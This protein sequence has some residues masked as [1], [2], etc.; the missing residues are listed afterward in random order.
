M[1]AGSTIT[2][3]FIRA[4]PKTDL[5]VH[6]DGSLRLSTLIE[7]ARR[8][9]VP[10]PSYDESGL[11]T[12]VFKEAYADLG[13]YLRGFAYTCAVLQSADN[14]ERVAYELAAD[15]IAEG[16]RYV[17]VRFAPQLHV[18]DA[19][20]LEQV[21][22]AVAAGMQRAK[23]EHNVRSEVRAQDDVPFEFGLILCAMRSFNEHMGPY[24]ARLLSVMDHTPRKRVFA[25]ASVELARAA[26]ILARESAL[27]VVGFDLAG[28]ESGFPAIDHREAYQ[29]AQ[30]NFLSKTVHAGE[31]YGPESIFQAIT[32]CHTNR[33]GHGTFLFD[34][35]KVQDDDV[36]DAAAYTR[37]LAEYIAARRITVEVCPTSN[38]QTTPQIRSVAEHPV[39]R[40]IEYGMSVTI[41]TDNRLVSNTTVS[42]ELELVAE[43]LPITRRQFRN[44]VVAGFKGSFFP[45]PYR[46]KRAFVRAAIDR[47]ERLERELLG[48]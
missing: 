9:G 42:R 37:S 4:I 1:I 8:E 17:E 7:L 47:Y 24:F 44:L 28:E 14:L 39:G 12:L 25:A 29:L 13:E 33:I 27:P 11:R 34:S 20:S 30:R 2:R 16:V 6:L 26:A 32:E 31:A 36:D 22:S 23:V 46:E 43:H 5:H 38:L 45:G 19:L 3:E 35:E 40:M 18:H 41:C 10:L 48:E 21:V 15:N